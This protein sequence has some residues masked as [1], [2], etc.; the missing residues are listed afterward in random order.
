MDE[1]DA[2]PPSSRETPDIIAREAGLRGRCSLSRAGGARSIARVVE[3]GWNAAR[4][5]GTPPITAPSWSRSSRGGDLQH[6][7]GRERARLEPQGPGG[8]GWRAPRGS[9]SSA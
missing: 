1:V 7:E 5:K 2:T 3:L 9:R 6:V 8:A 4:H